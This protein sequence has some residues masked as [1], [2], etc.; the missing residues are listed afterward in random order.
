MMFASVDDSL[1]ILQHFGDLEKKGKVY[2]DAVKMLERTF[3][4]KYKGLAR[5]L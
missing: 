4:E 3:P 2:S 1:F 5:L